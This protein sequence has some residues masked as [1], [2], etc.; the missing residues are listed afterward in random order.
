MNSLISR[1]SRPSSSTVHVAPSGATRN[2]NDIWS[3]S[4]RSTSTARSRAA[5]TGARRATK[6][7]PVALSSRSRVPFVERAYG[8]PPWL[9]RN[10]TSGE[11][12][13][14]FFSAPRLITS[15]QPHMSSDGESKTIAW[16]ERM[17]P[18]SP[19]TTARISR[20][21]A[22]RISVFWPVIWRASRAEVGITASRRLRAMLTSSF[23]R[24]IRRRATERVCRRCRRRARG[25]RHYGGRWGAGSRPGGRRGS[26]RSGWCGLRP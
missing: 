17:G 20:M 4:P 14:T 18:S 9:T 10:R 26:R 16:P 7:R 11:S 1:R 6:S 13:R 15:Y 12:A 24:W 3:M 2:A 5:C 23:L 19:S 8:T 21:V 25:P 22:V